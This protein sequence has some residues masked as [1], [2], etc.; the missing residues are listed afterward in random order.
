MTYHIHL[1]HDNFATNLGNVSS[2][3]HQTFDRV[4]S[5]FRTATVWNS[6]DPFWGEEYSFSLSSHHLQTL[7]VYI[8]DE[9]AHL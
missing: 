3:S 4:C 7:S 2:G 9:D 6:L 1:L 8:Y 5:C